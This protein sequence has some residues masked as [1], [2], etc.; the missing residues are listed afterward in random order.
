MFQRMTLWISLP[1]FLSLMLTVSATAKPKVDSK[2][3]PTPTSI[4]EVSRNPAFFDGKVVS[5][6]ATVASGFEVFAIRSSDE[7]CGGMWLEYSEGGPT[8]STST[9][10]SRQRRARVTVLK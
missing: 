3:I 1:F 6:R 9:A 10:V 2:T 8:A 4:C 5:L 7:D